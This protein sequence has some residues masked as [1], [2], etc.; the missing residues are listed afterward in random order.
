[1]VRTYVAAC[2]AGDLERVFALLHDEFVLAESDTLPGAV[3]TSG[4]EEARRYFAGFQKHWSEANWQPHDMVARG[5]RVWMPARLVLRGRKSG[6][7][8]DRVWQYVFTVRDGKLLRQDGYD[9]E[10]EARAAA[11]LD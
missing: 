4:P 2:N 5:E 9:D 3:T 8:V 11:G 1:M 6:V 7:V 10:A